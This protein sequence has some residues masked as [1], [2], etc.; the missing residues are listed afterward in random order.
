LEQQVHGK[1]GRP[2]NCRTGRRK[3]AFPVQR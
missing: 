2:P 1:H 3:I